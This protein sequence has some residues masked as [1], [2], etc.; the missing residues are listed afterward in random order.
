MSHVFISYSKKNQEYARK[1]AD[2]LL[3]LGFDVWIDDR[4]DY[5]DD[6]WRTIVRNI[7]SAQAFIVIMTD[8]SDASEWV[9]REVTLADKH[10]VPAFPIW[11]DGDF[12]ESENW[13]IYVR[14]QYVDVRKDKLP[15]EDFYRRIERVAPKKDSNGN[16][17]AAAS[18]S[19]KL[20]AY[21]KVDG[22]S[23]EFSVDIAKEPKA[24][25]SASFTPP[26]VSHILP[27][28]FEW[29]EIPAGKVTIEYSDTDHKIFD[30][31]RFWMA[32]YPITNAQYQIFL[33][34][35]D[36]YRNPA[37]WGFS[38]AANLW[39]H[40]N[41]HPYE[42]AF[43][44]DKLPR[45]NV[46]WYEAVAFSH[47][48]SLKLGLSTH[49]PSTGE[50]I[51]KSMMAKLYKIALPTEM[52][53]QRSAQGDDGRKYPWGNTLGLFPYNRTALWQDSVSRPLP[54]MDFINR[55]SPFGIL[56]MVGNVWEW[57]ATNWE[58]GD[59]N[60]GDAL[61]RVLRGC[62]HYAGSERADITFRTAESPNFSNNGSGFRIICVSSFKR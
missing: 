60:L 7:R 15:P 46:T 2:H 57:C 49:I 47:W 3:S 59:A 48:L 42:T 51:T 62:A 24:Q 14:T 18:D 54:V 26:D 40:E 19:S 34:A 39:W 16:N 9:Q 56:G 1:L 32:K 17:K 33:D 25:L 21:G 30:V 23:A 12:H 35:V 53:W 28:P 36:G 5:G 55:A 8:E 58:S 31:P 41:K 27:A 20:V 43:E 44:G 45:T 22:I 61:P 29:C 6:W 11:L 37:S 10:K 13:A 50:L 38:Q 52:Q 4:I